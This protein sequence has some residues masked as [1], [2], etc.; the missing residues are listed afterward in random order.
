MG[1]SDSGI[2][3]SSPYINTPI[4]AVCVELANAINER[5]AASNYAKIIGG[6]TFADYPLI[7]ITEEDDNPSSS[8]LT[9]RRQYKMYETSKNQYKP[10][11]VSNSPL[12]CITDAL[13]IEM[14]IIFGRIDLEDL[15]ISELPRDIKEVTIWGFPQAYDNSNPEEMNNLEWVESMTPLSNG[16]GTKIVDNDSSLFTSLGYLKKS[17]I[18][19]LW[20]LMK[21]YKYMFFY[22][23]VTTTQ[24]IRI[25]GE[26]VASFGTTYASTSF[27]S[28]SPPVQ[29]PT[30]VLIRSGVDIT[31][32]N[33]DN[34][35]LT[36]DLSETIFS[37]VPDLVDS[38]KYRMT[39][40]GPDGT[41][42][43]LL[44][45]GFYE[46]NSTID[47]TSI[48]I[49]IFST[50]EGDKPGSIS[51]P[52]GDEFWGTSVRNVSTG[53]GVSVS[54]LCFDLTTST[55]LEYSA[56]GT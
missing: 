20:E 24:R 17:I 29:Q 52:S 27:I 1:W 6:G 23:G 35:Q 28:Q 26:P 50:P 2:N 3:W 34:S 8:I 10:F 48:T 33:I 45:E 39:Q 30:N 37:S 25:L 51:L 55:D 14:A 36:Y 18:T 13:S 22:G 5:Y 49:D 54:H 21:S 19:E 9:G 7:A 47:S 41:I 15:S 46:A 53:S 31:V 56:D 32:F 44:A 42:D 43:E 38:F 11:D 4:W 16:V 40:T 12:I